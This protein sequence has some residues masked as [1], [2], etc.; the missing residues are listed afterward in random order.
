MWDLL[1]V[2]GTV[3]LVVVGV[4]GMIL[5]GV[6]IWMIPMTILATL[7]W[8]LNSQFN[9]LPIWGWWHFEAAA[10]GLSLLTGVLGKLFRSNVTINKK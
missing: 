4:V 1:E 9:W 6:L 10:V 7:A 3:L 5:L 2:V 8:Y